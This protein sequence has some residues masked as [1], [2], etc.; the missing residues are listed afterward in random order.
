MPRYLLRSKP[1]V[2]IGFAR[3]LLAGAALGAA[4]SERLPF[5]RLLTV[6]LLVCLAQ[7]LALLAGDGSIAYVMWFS[8]FGFL[9]YFLVPFFVKALA[10]ADPDGRS[11]VL[12]PAAQYSGAGLGPLFASFVGAPGQYHGGLLVTL[13]FIA[14]S[15][16][17]LWIGLI[18]R[19]GR[20]A[21]R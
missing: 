19:Q 8:A 13:G 21:A 6:G 16:A 20:R 10:A 3:Q 9:G 5:G 1:R 12:F 18:N 4:L 17:C 11:V 15:V 14:V 7:V 2:R